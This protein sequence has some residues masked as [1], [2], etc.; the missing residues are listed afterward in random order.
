MLHSR[1]GSPP[2]YFAVYRWGHWWILSRTF[3]YIKRSLSVCTYMRVYFWGPYLNSYTLDSAST[4]LISH[5][6][7]IYRETLIG[8]WNH[9]S[10]PF[11]HLVEAIHREQH[12]R[13]YSHV[14][15]GIRVIRPRD[16]RS[17]LVNDLKD[18]VEYYH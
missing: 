7:C 5:V 2:S 14:L 11:D 4:D 17:S 8:T 3:E 9:L 1:V 15:V 10:K 18:W 12:S 16:S 6:P 13:S